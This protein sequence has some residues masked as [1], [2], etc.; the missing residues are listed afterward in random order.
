[1]EWTAT[2][3]IVQ[4]L[5]GFAGAH[6]AAAALHDHRFGGVRHCGQETHSTGSDR[7]PLNEMISAGA[8][9]SSRPCT[10]KNRP[11]VEE[12]AAWTIRST[13]RLPSIGRSSRSFRMSGNERTGCG[14]SSR[15]SRVSASVPWRNASQSAPTAEAV[16][17]LGHDVLAG[18]PSRCHFSSPSSAGVSH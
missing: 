7:G 5:A 13:P 1:M 2:N 3:L 10:D 6:C 9:P 16:T 14:S 15:R 12:I 11:A 4:T 8:A 17:Y 18:G